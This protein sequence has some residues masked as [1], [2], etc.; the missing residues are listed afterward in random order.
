[1]ADYTTIDIVKRRLEINDTSR[2]T[3][4]HLAIAAAS[5]SI[6]RDCGREFG[7]ATSG[8]KIYDTHT[9]VPNNFRPRRNLYTIIWVYLSMTL[10]QLM[11]NWFWSTLQTPVVVMVGRLGLTI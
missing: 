5:R 9:K 6:D 8:T 7:P 11:T 1:M 2:D 10:P 4:L 3:D